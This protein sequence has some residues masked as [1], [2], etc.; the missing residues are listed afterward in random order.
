MHIY[1][2]INFNHVTTSQNNKEMLQ[3][4][5]V[6]FWSFCKEIWHAYGFR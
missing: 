6:N 3:E 1:F 2:F 4:H 5:R